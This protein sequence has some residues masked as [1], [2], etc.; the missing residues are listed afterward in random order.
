M[1]LKNYLKKLSMPQ[2]RV[3]ANSV[4]TSYEYLKQIANRHRAPGASICI[5][6]EHATEGTVHR[7]ELRPDYWEPDVY[8][9]RKVS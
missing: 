3:F 4:G 7:S 5:R 8:S 2:R 6:I 1:E 9:Q